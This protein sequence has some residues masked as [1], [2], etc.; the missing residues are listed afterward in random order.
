MLCSP[1]TFD[2]SIV[3]I[4]VTLL[5]GACLLIIP[6]NAK[7]QSKKLLNLIHR[8]NKVTVIQV[9]WLILTWG[10]FNRASAH[11][12]SLNL[13]FGYREFWRALSSALSD[14]HVQGLK[15]GVI[16]LCTVVYEQCLS[17][18]WMNIHTC[19]CTHFPQDCDFSITPIPKIRGHMEK[20][21][22]ISSK[23][24][25]YQYIYI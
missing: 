5:S 15:G 24:T 9:W 3:E 10:E 23:Q 8:R 12:R 25:N 4:F 18:I 2:P 11:I 13:C 22:N 19:T 14:E 1:L 6:D 17:L 16:P 20:I 7:L 21:E